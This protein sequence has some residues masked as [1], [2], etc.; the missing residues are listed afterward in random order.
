V[1][2]FRK[3]GYVVIV[4]GESDAQTLWLHEIPALGLPGAAAWSEER[5][6]PLFE[7]IPLIFVVIEPDKDGAAMLACLSRSSIA[8]RARLVRMP[9]ATKDPSALYLIDPEGF[10]AAFAALLEAAQP[11]HPGFANGQADADKSAKQPNE[12]TAYRSTIF[13]RTCRCTITSTLRHGQPGQPR[14]SMHAFR[15]SQ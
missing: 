2:E 3:T 14:A 4:E 8:S 6:A 5:D 15:R 11:A 9:P 1:E 10:P 7:Q 13:M 12:I